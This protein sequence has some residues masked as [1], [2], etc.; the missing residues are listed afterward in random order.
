MIQ[1]F[2]AEVY[3]ILGCVYGIQMNVSPEKYVSIC[4]DSHAALNAL[5]V[6]KTTSPLVRKCQKS[7]NDISPGHTVGPYWVP[8]HAGIREN[9][10]S[11]KVAR[12]GSIQKFVGPEPSL[13]VS[14]QNIKRTMKRWVDN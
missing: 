3:A 14:T 9:E 5:Q 13:W 1:F 7:F 10:I 6:A 2:Q 12:D 8:G 11:D 4:S